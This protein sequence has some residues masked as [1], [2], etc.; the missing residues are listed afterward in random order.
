[1][2]TWR[3]A[4]QGLIAAAGLMAAAPAMAAPTAASLFYERAVMTAADASCRLFAPPVAA[5]LA[6]A[7]AQARGAALRSGADAG[8]LQALEARAWSAV[9]SAGCTSQDITLAAARVRHAFD[10][11]ARLDTM[12]FPGDAAGWL[13]QRPADDGLSHW[14]L[15]QRARFGWDT[16]M[17]GLAGR[18]AS[19][20]LMAVANFA[21]GARPYGAR[22]IMRDAARTMGPYLDV[23]QADINGRLP[24]D[25]RLPPISAAQVFNAEAMS[26]AGRDLRPADLDDG[27]AFRFPAA[28]VEALAAL[29][30]R[31]SVAVEFLFAGDNGEESRTAYVEV[32]D[33]AAGRAFQSI[34]RALAQR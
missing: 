22:L 14:R 12:S 30:P 18:G 15:T 32:G 21:D 13:A 23:R 4:A 6:A 16:M 7:K 31:E 8:A 5:S 25:A 33:F 24:L 29:D 26:P 19:R 17:F 28:A 3:R 34:G 10:G 27:W 2:A 11:Y 20:P 9:Q 1:M